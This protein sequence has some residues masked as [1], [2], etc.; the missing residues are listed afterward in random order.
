[1]P[2]QSDYKQDIKIM[3]YAA[4]ILTYTNIGNDDSVVKTRP[5]NQ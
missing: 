5:K 2:R 3:V 4:F 1:M